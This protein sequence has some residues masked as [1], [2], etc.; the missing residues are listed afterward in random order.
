MPQ[1]VLGTRGSSLAL[2]QASHVARRLTT[3]HHD[4]EIEQRIIRTEGDVRP[5]A[6]FGRGDVGVFVRRIETA[7]AECEIDLAVHSLKDLP[8]TQPDGMT[9]AAVLERHDPRDALLSTQGFTLETLPAAATVAT[10]SPRRRT[11]LL[12]VRADLRIVPVRGNVDTRVGKLLDGGFDALVLALAGIERLGI[13]NVPARPLEP[14]ICL[15]AVG[16]GAL[17][18]ET[19]ASD[20]GTRDLVAG[21]EDTPTRQAV[22]AERA[23][24]RVLGGGCLAPATAY[25]RIGGGTLRLVAM[26]GD[27]N[28]ATEIRD[29]ESGR[30]EEAERLGEQLARR[31]LDAGAD[32]LLRAAR[33]E[34][35]GDAG[36]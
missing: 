20:R 26:V 10:G 15:P 17:A 13:T 27:G 8:T 32:E 21:L 5:H 35:G 2:W 11:Q 28:G 16:Q 29:R 14:E 1:L 24:L 30:A 6:T 34:G 9:I 4:L 19:R 23:F 7:L 3:L 12:R 33:E 18:V 36:P 22:D 25:A 31:M